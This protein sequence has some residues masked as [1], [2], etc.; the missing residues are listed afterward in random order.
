MCG[1]REFS[2]ALCGQAEIVRYHDRHVRQRLTL[3]GP[4][5]CSQCARPSS[6][7]IISPEI[8]RYSRWRRGLNSQ[9]NAPTLSPAIIRRT[10]ASLHPPA[11][12]T[13]LLR[14]QFS[15]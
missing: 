7:K 10:A 12:H 3:A 13:G 6:A 2:Y 8:Q 4:A 5:A 9:A 15:S 11:K 14:H 1:K